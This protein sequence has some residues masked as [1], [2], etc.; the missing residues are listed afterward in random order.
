MTT[1]PAVAGLLQGKQDLVDTVVLLR[2][3]VT[4]TPAGS[5]VS[6]PRS[7]FLQLLSGTVLLGVAF[8]ACWR[9]LDDAE[10]EEIAAEVA[11]AF[12]KVS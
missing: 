11:L 10:R 4:R 7:M 1:S 2:R 8:E 5:E 9:R 12:P 6:A 3:G